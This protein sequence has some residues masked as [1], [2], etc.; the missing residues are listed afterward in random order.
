MAIRLLDAAFRQSYFAVGYQHDRAQALVNAIGG[1]VTVKFYAGAVLRKTQVHGP[2]TIVSATPRRVQVGAWQSSSALTGSGAVTRITLG[3]ASVEYLQL[4]T[5]APSAIAFSGPLSADYPEDLSALLV[6]MDA[7]LP[8]S[9]APPI[10]LTSADLQLV[11]MFKVP[12]ETPELVNM[13]YCNGGF[14]LK[15]GGAQ[16][17]FYVSGQRPSLSNGYLVRTALIQAPA[18]LSGPNESSVSAI[19]AATSLQVNVD[20][21]DG[22]VTRIF[23]ANG[24]FSSSNGINVLGTAYDA[25]TNSLTYALAPFYGEA[26]EN[27]YAGGFFRRS[28]DLTVIGST[29][30]P[31]KLT[32]IHPRRSPGSLVKLPSALAAQWGV[33]PFV[34]VGSAGLSVFSTAGNGPC[35]YA[36]DPADIATPGAA[37]PSDVLANYTYDI[38][39]AQR[40]TFSEAM[41]STLEA[42]TY[43]TANGEHGVIHSIKNNWWDWTSHL[44]G[45]VVFLPE[46]GVAAF[47]GA[48]GEGRNFYS[49]DGDPLAAGMVWSASGPTAAAP[50]P[51]VD[52]TYPVGNA[53]RG[54]PFKRTALVVPLDEYAAVIAG[55]KQPHQ[56]QASNKIDLPGHNF[57]LSLN[58]SSGSCA[59]GEEHSGYTSVGVDYDA[60]TGRIYELLGGVSQIQGTFGD[61]IVRVYQVV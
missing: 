8:V 44:R 11:G 34:S 58:Q 40:K 47:F 14:S 7:A 19:P 48:W 52:P 56:V 60:S 28:A 4:D 21:L 25:A 5:Q 32:G 50:V 51:V 55:T 16:P 61:A 49:S 20:A 27:E 45:G 9:V 17:Q 37:I 43:S 54:Y 15:A 2:L 6:A 29:V 31:V 18:I 35:L 24:A 1:A 13:T 42:L 57:T 26:P 39:P 33:R 3:S 12:V 53:P 41:G 59:P 36:F 23:S 38:N 30:G 46:R 22:S 10:G